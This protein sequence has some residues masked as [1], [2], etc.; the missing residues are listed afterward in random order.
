MKVKIPPEIKVGIYN[1]QVK[2]TPN[3]HRDAAVYGRVCTN[4]GVLELD[5]DMPDH[6]KYTTFWHEV[7]HIVQDCYRLSLSDDDV[8]RLAQGLSQILL[9]NLGIELDFKEIKNENIYQN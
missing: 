7:I 8:D 4:A 5:L 9:N 2:Y 1:Y 6:I 3:L